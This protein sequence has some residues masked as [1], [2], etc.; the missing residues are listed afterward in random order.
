[1]EQIGSKHSFKQFPD[2]VNFTRP[3]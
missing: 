3:L 2:T 1:M